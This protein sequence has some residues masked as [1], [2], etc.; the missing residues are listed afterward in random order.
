[1]RKLPF[2]KVINSYVV[3]MVSKFKEKKDQK[4]QNTLN[5]IKVY[6][7]ITYLNSNDLSRLWKFNNSIQ[8]THKPMKV[9]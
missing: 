2:K 7:L 1:M 6:R 4:M 3:G 5:V 9:C 8:V